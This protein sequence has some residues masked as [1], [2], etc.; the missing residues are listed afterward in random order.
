MVI[1]IIA[2]IVVSTNLQSQ[3][4]LNS[5]KEKRNLSWSILYCTIAYYINV[6][7]KI[8]YCYVH[9]FY[10][11]DNRPRYD[12]QL[13]EDDI[14]NQARQLLLGFIH[15]RLRNDGISDIEP[16]MLQDPSTPSG[17][18]IEHVSEVAMALRRIGDE[19][20]GDAHLQQSVKQFKALILS[21]STFYFSLIHWDDHLTHSSFV[22]FQSCWEDISRF[23]AR[24]IHEH[25]PTD[26]WKW[27]DKLGSDRHSV[28][29][30]LQDDSQGL[31]ETIIHLYLLRILVESVAQVI[32]RRTQIK[33]SRVQVPKLG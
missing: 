3:N 2:Y 27:T 7:V 30:C 25:R 17:P 10:C 21:W 19:L 18:P 31:L 23:S 11:P 5:P 13:S 22:I 33:G 14:G 24:Y 28:L 16:H 4:F 29:F 8:C 6:C 1:T 26:L 12:R 15:D 20:D 32:G 9:Y